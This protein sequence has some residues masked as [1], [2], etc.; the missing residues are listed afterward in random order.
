VSPITHALEGYL[1][2]QPLE[3]RSDRAL[4]TLMSVIPDI[5]GLSLVLGHESYQKYHHTVGH[6]LLFAMLSTA[7]VFVLAKDKVRSSALGVA[8]FH[9]HLLSDL[10][11]SG[12]DWTILYLWPSPT[13]EWQFSPPFVWE[14]SSWQNMLVTAIA[15][16]AIVAV[17]LY[18][19][20][21]FLEFFSSQSDARVVAVLEKW[22][23]R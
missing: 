3:N 5:D 9:A 18:K 15:L 20:R 1:L 2:A 8:A 23:G 13:P 16:V 22:A 19:R 21:T 11:G 4:V 12:A 10:L 17:A 6:S 14:L 7:A